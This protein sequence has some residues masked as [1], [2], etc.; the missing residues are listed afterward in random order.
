MMKHVQVKYLLLQELVRRDRIKLHKVDTKK[1]AVDI[2]TKN[3][4]RASLEFHK[5]S[6]GITA[7]P[8]ETEIGAASVLAT[9]GGTPAEQMF[10]G[11]RMCLLGFIALLATVAPAKS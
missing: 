6:S 1:D 3:T 7:L 11:I 5:K 8:R 9:A 2:L 4:D 10:E